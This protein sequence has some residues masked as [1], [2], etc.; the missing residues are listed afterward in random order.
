MRFSL[1][2]SRVFGG[3][4]STFLTA[5]HE[6]LPKSDPVEQYEL[7][8][9]LYQL[10][11]YLNHTVLFGVRRRYHGNIALMLIATFHCQ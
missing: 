11:H 2:L 6:I 5:Y 8:S 4:P 10:Y 1:A 7:R 3:F 9:D